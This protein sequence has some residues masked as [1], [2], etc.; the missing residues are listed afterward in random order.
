MPCST[1]TNSES[2]CSNGD[3]PYPQFSPNRPY[4]FW[5]SRAHSSLPSKSNALRMPVPVIAQTARP[6]VTGDGVDM[7]CFCS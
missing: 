1:C 2:P 5:M 6:S 4:S 3:D 7:F